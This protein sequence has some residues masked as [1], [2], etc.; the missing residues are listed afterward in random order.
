MA[1]STRPRRHSVA[2]T[3]PLPNSD[4]GAAL[5]DLFR[6]AL[7]AGIHPPGCGCGVGFAQAITSAAL[8]ADL[9]DYLYPHYE[10]SNA[11]ELAAFVQARID[12]GTGGFTS[13]LRALDNAALSETDI[14]R[15][16]DDLTRVLES[17]AQVAQPGGRFA[18][19]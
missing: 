2:R 10:K 4:R 18:C 17:M 19:T 5:A 6:D 14:T 15:L 13:W 7:A 1:A 8:E 3:V 12:A 9:L 16:F 11:R